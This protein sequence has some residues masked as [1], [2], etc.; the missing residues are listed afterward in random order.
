VGL[1]DADLAAWSAGG[2]EI[3]EQV[4]VTG[5]VDGVR[6]RLDAMGEQGVTELVYQPAGPDIAR[7]LERFMYAAAR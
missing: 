2:A 5:T 6:R 3:V 4:T 7:E 1:N